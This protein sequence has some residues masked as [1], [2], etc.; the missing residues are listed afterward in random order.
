MGGSYDLLPTTV[1]SLETA[2]PCVINNLVSFS[3][4]FA[5]GPGNYAIAVGS[6]GVDTV[7][8]EGNAKFSV[9]LQGAAIPEP[10]TWAVMLAGFGAI[11]GASMRSARRRT[12]LA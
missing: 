3:G 7:K 12:A 11:G 10:A 9:E 1:I 8:T 5:L 4:E 2:T 6:S